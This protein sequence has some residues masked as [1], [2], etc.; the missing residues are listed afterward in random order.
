M[1]PDVGGGVRRL[2]SSWQ[3]HPRFDGTEQW[4]P[5]PGRAGQDARSRQR[6][7]PACLIPP[8][9]A[10]AHNPALAS[11]CARF[12][13]GGYGW[14][15]EDSTFLPAIFPSL[16][17]TS[18]S[19]LPGNEGPP[20][21]RKHCFFGNTRRLSFCVGLA[22]CRT[23][24]V[25]R[26]ASLRRDKP[27]GIGAAHARRGLSPPLGSRADAPAEAFVPERHRKPNR[28]ERPGRAARGSA[29]ARRA[30]RLALSVWLIFWGPGMVAFRHEART[31]AGRKPRP[32]RGM[33]CGL[34][35][36]LPAA[37]GGGHYI[38]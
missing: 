37:C 2:P 26:G 14:E 24:V 38:A 16:E 17:T 23:L 29:N 25:F 10:H 32:H 9:A 3:T 8:T 15:G 34:A 11:I 28:T 5:S 35:L 18:L 30:A 27:A 13:R 19:S 36:A 12:D 33:F 21:A 6:L 7:C 31:G 22:C 1:T 4:Q 20:E